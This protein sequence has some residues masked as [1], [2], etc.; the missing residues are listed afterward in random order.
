MN[1]NCNQLGNSL[2]KPL[3]SDPLLISR[4][5]S[6]ASYEFANTKHGLRHRVELK[7]SQKQ[8]Y[9]KKDLSVIVE[10]SFAK[11]K[12]FA[13]E[14]SNAGVKFSDSTNVHIFIC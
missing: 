14:V 5:D 7:V 11:I 6:W 13:H 9:N 10:V 1:D 2:Q 4:F 3:L 8:Q 12:Q